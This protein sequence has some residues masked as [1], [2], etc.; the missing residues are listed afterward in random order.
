MSFFGGS[1]NT[2]QPPSKQLGLNNN[3]SATN[4]QGNPLPYLAGKRRFAGTFITDAF[5]QATSQVSSGGGKNSGKGGGGNSGTNYYASFAVAFC[6]G[7][8]DGFHDL[9]L[10]GDAVYTDNTPLSP[11]S[12]KEANNIATFQTSSAHGLTSGQ[13]V[14]INGADQPEFN[15]EFIITVVSPT[16]FQYTIPGTTLTT[17]TASGQIYAWIRLDAIY[18]GNED[19]ITVTIPNYGTMTLYWGTET[20]PADDYLQVSGTNHSPM[21]GVCYA[22][23][24]QLFLGLNQTNIQNI[25]IVLSRNPAPAWLTSPAHAKIS[26]EA[27]PAAVFYDLL[28]NPHCGLGLTDSDFNLNTLAAAATEF[29]TEGLGIS[30]IITRGDTALSLLSE[31][32]S[33]VDAT[34]QLDSNCKLIIKPV[35]AP[36]DYTALPVLVDA[37]LADLPKPTTADWSNVYNQTRIVFPNRDAAW[38]DDFVEWF[39]FSATNANQKTAQ[40]QTLQHDWITQRGIANA[41]VQ[42]VGPAAAV[43][44]QTGTLDL[45]FTTALWAAMQPGTLFKN[46]FANLTSARANGIFCVTKRTFDDPASPHF[47]VE[48]KSDRSYLNL[49]AAAIYHSNS[50]GGGAGGNPV[51]ALVDIPVNS[52]YGIVELPVALCPSGRPAIAALVARDMQNTVVA[53]LWLGRNFAFNGSPAESYLLLST[54][55]TFAL[56]GSLAADFP[57]ATAFVSITNA[58]PSEATGNPF[59]L[60]TGLLIQ[61]DGPD[62]ILPEV[63]DFDA[64]ANTLLLFVGNEIMSVAEATLTASGAYGLTVIRGR[65]GTAI[66]DHSASDTVMIIS[67]TDLVALQHPH[68]LAGNTAEFKLAL[69]TQQVSDVDAFNMIFAGTNWNFPVYLQQLPNP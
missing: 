25:E 12:L 24:H 6:I 63:C 8:C 39:D 5:D 17:E 66:A 23:F 44:L 34:L 64:L 69:G 32:C 38:L 18:R 20:Q 56:H 61:L 49:S 31:L 21:H 13:S 50:V 48:Y 29:F 43:P 27:N 35:R 52:R 45:L 28:T 53:K 15:G 65:F 10:N 62:L 30:P 40:P 3:S 19:S 54:I 33:S 68:F 67:L 51:P 4:E 7:P 16:Q 55:T 42:A 37:Q 41:L 60:T 26:D 36:A 57:A 47:K 11:V 14:V 2:A 59:P 58:L 1:Q 46:T 9:F 22:V